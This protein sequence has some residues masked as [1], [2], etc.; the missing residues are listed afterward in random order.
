MPLERAPFHETMRPSD[1]NGDDRPVS[2][3]VSRPPPRGGRISRT[4]QRPHGEGRHGHW[5]EE[6][7]RETSPEIMRTVDE[8]LRRCKTATSARR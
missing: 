7:D 8:R 4:R 2:P 1:P 6:P 5:I 3:S